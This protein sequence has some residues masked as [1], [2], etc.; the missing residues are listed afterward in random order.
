[1]AGKKLTFRL[2]PARIFMGVFLLFFLG[3]TIYR[4]ATGMG[5]T[6]LDDAWTWGLWI[7]ADLSAICFAGAGFSMAFMTHV[8]HMEKFEALARR[9]LLISMVGYIFTLLVLVIEIGRWENFY[10]PILHPNL[11]SPMTE[12]L[13]CILVYFILQVIEVIEV[14]LEKYSPRGKKLLMKIMTVVYII[15]A[16]V[17]F[18]H[19]ASLGAIYLAMPNKLHPIFATNAMPWL[20]LMS[21]FFVGF[22]VVTLE[23]MWASKHYKKEYDG[24]LVSDLLRIGAGI[25]GVYFIWR[26]ADVAVRGQMG[27]V[28]SGTFEGNMFII[29]MLLILVPVVMGLLNKVKTKGAQAA[30]ATMIIL[31]VF[32]YRLNVIYVG[33]TNHLG[34]AYIPSWVEIV[35]T[36]GVLFISLLLYL[37]AIE[38]LPFYGLVPAKGQHLPRFV[39]A[40]D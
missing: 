30:Y 32:M 33:M 24:Q 20:F 10:Q 23:Y 12:V 11:H 6:N 29:E 4:L 22:S 35:M 25:A 39:D 37:F 17:P 2:T 19:Q 40:E 3:V 18:G 34:M 7:V 1:M 38:N 27:A 21:A 13:F 9:A 16:L 14:V 8:I 26:V 36:V 28:F 15:A 5:V 31:G